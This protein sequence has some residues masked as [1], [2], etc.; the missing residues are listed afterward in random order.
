MKDC[1]F[2]KIIKREAPAEIIFEN[3]HVISFYGLHSFTRAHVLVVPKKHIINLMDVKLEDAN[4]ITEI[5]FAI[6]TIAKQLGIDENGFRV[7][8]N[9]NK[10]GGQDVFHMHYH[11]VGGRQLKW[12]M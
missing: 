3:E 4:I 12:D 10:E 6:Q 7:I 9:T 2:C 1:I 5:H 11:L 8:T